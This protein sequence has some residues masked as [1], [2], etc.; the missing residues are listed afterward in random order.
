MFVVIFRNWICWFSG[1]SIIPNKSFKFFIFRLIFRLPTNACYFILWLNLL[2]FRF[3]YIHVVEF[4]FVS[5]IFILIFW[6]L[7]GVRFKKCDDDVDFGLIT[8]L[9]DWWADFSWFTNS[10]NSVFWFLIWHRLKNSCLCFDQRIKYFF[11]RH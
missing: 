9:V 10:F 1:S 7:L 11:L 8:L 2:I 5:D 3:S 4:S 6:W